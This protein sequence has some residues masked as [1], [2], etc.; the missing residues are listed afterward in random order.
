[1]SIRS[2]SKRRKLEEGGARRIQEDRTCYERPYGHQEEPPYA[3]SSHVPPVPPD[4]KRLQEDPP[5]GGFS[6]PRTAS[7]LKE[8]AFDREDSMSPE[9]GGMQTKG[10][11]CT[12]G[13]NTPSVA[14]AT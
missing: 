4:G 9:S 12:T 10:Q 5:S 7:P 8:E 13:M 6:D 14:R 2:L 11:L 3:R 1:M